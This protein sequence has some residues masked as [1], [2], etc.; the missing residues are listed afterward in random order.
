MYTYHQKVNKES[1]RTGTNYVS[2]KKNAKRGFW[3]EDNRPNTVSQN[4]APNIHSPIQLYKANNLNGALDE[5]S[6]ERRAEIESRGANSFS[7]DNLARATIILNTGQRVTIFASSIYNSAHSEENLIK[8]IT[9]KYGNEILKRDPSVDGQTRISE[10]Y[11]ERAPCNEHN[12]EWSRKNRT[13]TEKNCQSYLAKI[14]HQNIIV[15]HSVPNDGASHG[16]LMAAAK[17]RYVDEIVNDQRRLT[18]ENARNRTLYY[19]SVIR[20]RCNVLYGE[21]GRNYYSEVEK[22]KE[23]IKHFKATVEALG[24]RINFYTPLVQAFESIPHCNHQNNESELVLQ[25]LETAANNIQDEINDVLDAYY[26]ISIEETEESIGHLFHQRGEIEGICEKYHAEA[27]LSL[28][29]TQC[30][31]GETVDIRVQG[32]NHNSLMS[33]LERH[34][35][36]DYCITTDY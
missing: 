9:E 20:N 22:N 7:G 6:Y 34:Y 12:A 24:L 19:F 10:I 30:D 16:T 3:L 17:N 14:L 26:T 32:I 4:N 5:E 15:S 18:Y 27:S 31:G 1:V 25:A 13:N 35:R 33:D 36:I 21:Y 11:T 2:Q 28:G 23:Y 29:S 8:V